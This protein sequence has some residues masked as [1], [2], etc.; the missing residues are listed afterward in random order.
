M[1]EALLRV[2]GPDGTLV[3]YA[4]WEA[5]YEVLLD[6]GGRV[7]EEWRAHVPPFDPARSRAARDNGAFVEFLRTTPGALRSGNSG[8]SVV[9]LGAKAEV[10]TANHPLDYG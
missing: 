8:A 7:P 10:L 1:G 5:R 6:A 2:L 4:D 9:A 3:G